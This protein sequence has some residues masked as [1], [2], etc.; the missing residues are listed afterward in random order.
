MREIDLFTNDVN[1]LNII[2]KKYKIL[3]LFTENKNLLKTKNSKNFKVFRVKS[4][5]N[6]RKYLTNSEF[7]L[8]YSFGLIIKK[9][10]IKSYSNGIWNIH[11]GDLP[12]YRGRHPITAAFINNEKKIG[13]CVHSI[14]RNIDMGV[15]L[16][17]IFV[18]RNY[19]DDEKTI[20]K[21]ILKKIPSLLNAA[22][23]NKK[24]KKGKILTRGFYHK[25][26]YGG[27]KINDSKKFDHIFIHNAAKSQKIH[28]GILVNNKKYYDS[29]FY[30]YK[31]LKKKN[32]EIIFCK[33]NKKL[34]LIK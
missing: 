32:S 9:E 27:I 12:K 16:S 21:K 13:I 19:I 7:A 34:I 29:Y 23:N 31:N 6:I 33:N 20:L 14:N 11:P 30:N 15:L 18:K 22:S 25:P 17:K 28:G 24:N 8:C 26:F 2:K 5:N 1:F 3:N 4:F 10:I